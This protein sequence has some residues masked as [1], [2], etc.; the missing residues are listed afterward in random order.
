[1]DGKYYRKTA[2]IVG[3]L[4]IIAT[5]TAITAMVL[6]GTAFEEPD[7]LVD[8]PEI[9]DKVVTAVVLELILAVSLIGIGALMFPVFKKH[10]EGLAL[11]YAGIRLVEAIFII[12]ASVCLL[13]MLTMGKDYSAG[14]LDVADIETIGALLMAI[15]EGAFLIG[16]LI[17]LGLGAMTLNYLFYRSELIP[18]WLSVWGIIGGAGVLVYGVLGLGGLD[19]GA[20]DASTLLAAPIAVQEMVFAVFLMVKGFDRPAMG[21]GPDTTEE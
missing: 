3:A 19:T 5:V 7:Y 6:L 9:E 20:T 8:L 17:F 13:V 11:G 2:M 12:V 21:S 18:R 16:T 15:R 1:M 10:G 4:F 14:N